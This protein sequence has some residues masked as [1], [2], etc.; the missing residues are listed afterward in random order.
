MP[1]FSFSVESNAK[2]IVAGLDTSSGTK[3]KHA[4]FGSDANIARIGKCEQTNSAA[5][6]GSID[7]ALVTAVLFTKGKAAPDLRHSSKINVS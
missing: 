1:D 4:L 7:M 3:V 2:K 5:D 6:I